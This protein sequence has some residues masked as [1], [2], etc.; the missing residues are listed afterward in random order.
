[1]TVA[2]FVSFL[3]LEIGIEFQ[4]HG[5]SAR[6]KQLAAGLLGSLACWQLVWAGWSETFFRQQARA[7]AQ[8]W[9][10]PL[11]WSELERLAWKTLAGG[12]GGESWERGGLCALAAWILLPAWLVLR[13]GAPGRLLGLG[14]LVPV[15]LSVGYSVSVR[16]I[17][18]VRYLIFAQTFLLL[19]LACTAAG[20]QKPWLRRLACAGL[21][22]W[23]S[24]WCWDY[25][26]RREVFAQASGLR[27][28]AEYL[29]AQ[30][31]PKAPVIVSSPFV[32]VPLSACLQAP[33]RACV[34]YGRELASDLL[35]GPPLL[36]ED[37]ERT[38]LAL[39]GSQT[40]LWTVD[41][42]GIFGGD[43]LVQVPGGYDVIRE[44]RFPERQGIPMDVQVRKL[45]RKA[46]GESPR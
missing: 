20:L 17:L 25:G 34:Q 1:L 16:N 46:D 6:L 27:Q 8:L 9:M 11:T 13:G 44:V 22:L 14:V 35:G 4:R 32:Y 18:G 40:T 42:L 3:L 24:I 28:A 30:R 21:L 12:A 39:N 5:V 33:E 2:G 19:G 36:P 31:L 23:S 15:A 43:V 41:A 38:S 29:N 7:N 45:R 10:H 26:Q 37:I